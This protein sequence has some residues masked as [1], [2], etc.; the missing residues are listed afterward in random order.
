VSFD[1]GGETERIREAYARRDRAGCSRL[2]DA[3]RPDVVYFA[4]RLR[5]TAAEALR[6]LGWESPAGRRILDVGCGAGGWLGTL[7]GGWNLP[8]PDRSFDLVTAQT[9]FSSITAPEGRSALSS[10]IKRVLRPSGAAQIFDFRLSRPGNP[11]TVGIGRR[12]VVR[13]FPGF[14][15]DRRTLNLAPPLAR[16][17]SG[18]GPRGLRRIESLLPFLRTHALYTLTR[19]DRQLVRFPGG[20]PG[21]AS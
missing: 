7:A 9:V 4:A 13:L 21:P 12:E 16:L 2:Y 11:D 15:L 19:R 20:I 6:S 18:T 8:F 17:L 10:E 1:P 5:E 3:Q 14:H